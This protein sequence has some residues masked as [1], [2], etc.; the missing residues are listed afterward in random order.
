MARAVARFISRQHRVRDEQRGS[1][2]QSSL[3]IRSRRHAPFAGSWDSQSPT[4]SRKS[5]ALPATA[6]RAAQSAGEVCGL[7]LRCWAVPGVLPSGARQGSGEF[8]LLVDERARTARRRPGDASTGPSERSERGKRTATRGVT[9]GPRAFSRWCE[10]RCETLR[11]SGPRG[12]NPPRRVRPRLLSRIERIL[13]APLQRIRLR[14]L[15]R[16][17][18]RRAGLSHG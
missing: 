5:A 4:P 8:A 1:R 9:S 16:S 2:E 17:S 10:L 7:R 3:V 14:D 15:P 12:F 13:L 18:P 11:A 6:E